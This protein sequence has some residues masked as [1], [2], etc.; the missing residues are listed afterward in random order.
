MKVLNSLVKFLFNAQLFADD[1]NANKP[2][3]NTTDTLSNDMKQ[4]YS[5]Y[6]ID[7]AQPELIHAQFGVKVPIPQGNGKTVIFRKYKPY[8]NAAELQEG[9]TPTGHSLTVTQENATVKQFGD[10]TTISDMVKLTAIDNNIAE[11]AELHGAQ[12][13]K[14]IDNIIRDTL[15]GVTNVQF[16]N[17]EVAETNKLVGGK[18]SGNHYL[19][20][21]AVKRAVRCLKKQN[22]PKINGSYVGIIHPDVAFDLMNDPEWIDAHKYASPE[23]LYNGEI[24]K[25]AG[26]RFVETTEAKIFYGAGSEGRDVYV[27]FVLGDKAYGVTEIS[28]GGIQHIFKPLG[29]GGTSDPLDQRSTAGW[30]A[31]I[32]AALL[33]PEY[34]VRIETTS[35]FT[36]AEEEA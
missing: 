32:A 30:K 7:N 24:G 4:Y 36:S 9:V 18:E 13:G 25:I 22:A 33:V 17:G 16:A 34:I 12:A 2:V 23:E 11:A 35:T 29:S 26:V 31:T 27:T 20:V 19:T 28:G 8:E 21:A 6:L 1:E 5:D 10:Y 15:A 14:T 3:L